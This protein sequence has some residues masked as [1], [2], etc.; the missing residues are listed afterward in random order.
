MTSLTLIN[1]K[2]HIE[3]TKGNKTL[4]VK[5]IENQL[6]VNFYLEFGTI[7]G[8]KTGQVYFAGE[9]SFDLTGYSSIKFKGNNVTIDYELC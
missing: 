8:F 5:L 3:F 2:E 4:K 6:S 1:D 9:Y 7:T